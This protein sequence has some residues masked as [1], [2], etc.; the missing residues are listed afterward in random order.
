[1]PQAQETQ[2]IEHFDS[3]ATFSSKQKLQQ[4]LKSGQTSACFFDKGRDAQNN[5]GKS[6]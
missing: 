3:F 4:A 5:F 6:T 1:M 2:G